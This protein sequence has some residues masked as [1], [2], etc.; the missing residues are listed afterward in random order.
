MDNLTRDLKIKS[1]ENDVNKLLE[2]MP[3]LEQLILLNHLPIRLGL[4]PG[5]DLIFEISNECRKDTTK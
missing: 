5:A 2:N 1:M 4:R 3:R